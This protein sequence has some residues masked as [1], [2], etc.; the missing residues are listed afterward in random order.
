MAATGMIDPMSAMM[1]YIQSEASPPGDTSNAPTDTKPKMRKGKK[2]PSDEEINDIAN[3]AVEHWAPRDRRMDEDLQLYRLT[4]ENQ[5]SGEVVQKNTPYVVVE[6]AAHMLAAQTPV[7][8]VIPAKQT[9]KEQAQKI[10]N[11]LRWSWVRWNKRW[12]R[13]QIQGSMWHSMAHFLCLRGWASARIWYDPEADPATD[14]PI[15]V[16]LFDPRQVYPMFGDNGLVYVIH[17]YWTT[18]GELNDEWEDAAK[19]FKDENPEDAIEVTEYYDEWFHALQVDGASIKKPTAHEYGFVP[20][21]IATG[22]GAPIRATPTDQTNWTQEVGVSMFHGIKSSYRSLNKLLS[23]LATQVANAANPARVYYYD[24]AATEVP[25]PID[26]TPGT[27]NYLFYDRERMETINTSPTPNDYAPLIDSLIDDVQKGTLPSILWGQTSGIETGFGMSMMTDAARDQ[28][29]AIVEAMEEMIEQ[30]NEYELRLIQDF[31]DGE[32][33]FWTRNTSGQ[34]QSGV[35]LSPDEVKAVGIEN[36]VKYRDI[37]PKDRAT[38]AQIATMLKK[39]QLISGDTARTDYLMI[40]NPEL[41]EQKI[42]RELVNQDEDVI[43]KGLVPLALYETDPELF[44]FYLT[45]KMAELM[46]PQPQMGAVPGAPPPQQGPQGPGGGPAPPGLSPGA[47][48]PLMNPAANPL[49]QSIGAAIGG[50]GGRPAGVGGAGALPGG[51]GISGLP[52]GI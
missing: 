48:A 42:L 30:T 40:D 31:V 6:K 28:L 25:E 52:I 10:E 14:L 50:M 12:R 4:Q 41:E 38:M 39:E 9:E 26:L 19:K 21:I 18:Y 34:A 37:S 47:Q 27:T 1:Q 29:Y 24:P 7:I 49:M 20:W 45:L 17:R 15:R 43:K 22:N 8:S 33:G 23:Q 36:E 13:S 44:Q 3:R 51:V 5:G 32:I 11:F 46:G 35:T 16:K 2:K